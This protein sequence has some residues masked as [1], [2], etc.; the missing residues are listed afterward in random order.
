MVTDGENT[1]GGGG[2][3]GPSRFTDFLRNFACRHVQFCAE[4]S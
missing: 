2:G 3:G 1:G 4:D